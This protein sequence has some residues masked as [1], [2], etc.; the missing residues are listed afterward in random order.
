MTKAAAKGYG[1]YGIRVNVVCPGHIETP[2]LGD[3][4]DDEERL[5]DLVSQYPI[6]RIGQPND[7][8]DAIIWLSS[9]SA[10][11]ITGVSLPVE[12]GITT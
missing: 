12:G 2:M 1:Q 11:F 10:S 5:A 9:D 7:L 6:G 4:V 8:A 3:V